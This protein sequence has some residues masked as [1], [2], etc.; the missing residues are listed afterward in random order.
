MK[1]LLEVIVRNL[2]DNPDAVVVTESVEN[3]VTVLQLKVDNDDM[4]K[5]IGKQGRI[6]KNIRTVIKA[7]AIHENKRVEVKIS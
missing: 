2:V 1:Q 6:A 4:G 3:D 7:A 5:I